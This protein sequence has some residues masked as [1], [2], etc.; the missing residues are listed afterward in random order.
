MPIEIRELNIK[1]SV[2]QNQQEQSTEQT[3]SVGGQPMP[4]KDSL[5]GEC[6]EQI[7]DILHN[8]DER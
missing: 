2:N 7:M 8:K 5:I 1:V 6:V 4:D 3:A